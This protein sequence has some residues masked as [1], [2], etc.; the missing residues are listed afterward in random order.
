[1]RRIPGFPAS[2]TADTIVQPVMAEVGSYK[3]L[4]ATGSISA[5][6]LLGNAPAGL[7]AMACYAE[8]SV[9]VGPAHLKVTGTWR[10]TVGARTVNVIP[11]QAI[12]ATADPLQVFYM[13]A[14]AGQ[15][16]AITVAT[17]LVSGT[18]TYDFT[19]VLFRLKNF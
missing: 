1:M 19:A 3:S 7:Y 8:A 18:L 6:T 16:T 2:T 4:G 15:N 5:V 14:H 12:T 13:V 9:S 10:D 11:D 17:T